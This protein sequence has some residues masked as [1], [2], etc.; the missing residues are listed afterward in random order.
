MIAPL[1]TD[2]TGRE[3]LTREVIGP[4]LD[5]RTLAERISAARAA[6]ADYP[7]HVSETE[8]RAAAI[9]L[10][11]LSPDRDDQTLARETRALLVRVT[12]KINNG[13]K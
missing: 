2:P 8:A 13:K 9:E 6:L 4:T 7:A 3:A 5:A 11:A 12:G 10:A 1:P